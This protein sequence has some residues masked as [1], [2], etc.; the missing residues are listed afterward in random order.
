[1]P[2]KSTFNSF[3]QRVIGAILPRS[4]ASIPHH[5]KVSTS[6]GLIVPLEEMGKRFTLGAMAPRSDES[7]YFLGPDD[8]VQAASFRFR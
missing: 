5:G 7:R 6:R 1:M 4:A 2:M 8:I 3:I